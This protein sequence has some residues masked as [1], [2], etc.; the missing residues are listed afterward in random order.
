MNDSQGKYISISSMRKIFLSSL[1]GQRLN[2][3]QILLGFLSDTNFNC[4]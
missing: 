3:L 2:W 4:A 1:H